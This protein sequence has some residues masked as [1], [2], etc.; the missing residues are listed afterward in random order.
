MA[1]P[2]DMMRKLTRGLDTRGFR[3]LHLLAPCPTGWK[4]EPSEGIELVRW[5]V[6][7]GLYPVLEIVDGTDWRISIEPTFSKEALEGFI[8]RQ[9]RFAKSGVSV[10]EVRKAVLR[11]W[12]SLR[13]RVG[14]PVA[15]PAPHV[16]AG[17]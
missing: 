17:E 14:H 6:Q 8:S 9:G 2:E 1:H 3:F 16:V 11:N 4:S 12:D 10:D 15:P 5:A 7:S 13:A